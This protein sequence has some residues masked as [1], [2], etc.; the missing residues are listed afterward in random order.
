VPAAGR[1]T[2][3]N[4]LI[5]VLLSA[6]W[7]VFSS[8]FT[9]ADGDFPAFY[10]AAVIA[11]QGDFHN[12]HN[13]QWQAEIER[14]LIPTRPLPVYF[15]R[16]HVYAAFLAP[17]ALLPVRPSFVVWIVWQAAMLLG[18]WYWAYRRFGSDAVALA[19][20][21]P[22]AIM[23]F[24][25]GQDPVLFLGLIVLSFFLY[26]R[27]WPMLSGFVLG[28][29]F[30]KP[31]LMLLMPVALG[32]QK[33]WRMLCGLVIA[34][35]A[36]AGASIAL[37]GWASVARYL[38]FLERQQQHLSPTPWRMMNVYAIALNFGIDNRVVSGALV[39][40]VLAAV[41]AICWRGEWW[42][43]LS[44]ALIGTFLIAPHAYLY[45]STLLMLPAL[46]V[47][48]QARN[49]FVRCVAAAVLTP[50]P[51]LL[52]LAEIPW[53]GVAAMLLLTLLLSL[54]GETTGLFRHLAGRPV[55]LV[56]RSAD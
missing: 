6:T 4:I 16:P 15:T 44:A 28:L 29:V 55:K 37:G 7:A 19:A 11:R 39:V 30:I 36:E 26:E 25:F 51:S 32:L 45:D 18:V 50:I 3:A 12:L 53:T 2:F 48:F 14:P 56:L 52:Q 27:K 43:G 8:R 5:A 13:E 46:L 34:G 35:I 10:V 21:F 40:V 17:F 42:Q 49:L 31:H 20:L 23:G 41:A 38:Q 47:M 1:K 54:A 9:L 24:A 33:R 22:P